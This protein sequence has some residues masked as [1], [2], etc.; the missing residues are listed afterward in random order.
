MCLTFCHSAPSL[1]ADF[2][3]QNMA[4]MQPYVHVHPT[5]WHRHRG[6]LGLDTNCRVGQSCRGLEYNK[7]S[8]LVWWLLNFLQLT[9]TST[10]KYDMHNRSV[11]IQTASIQSIHSL[12]LSFCV[13]IPFTR[14]RNLE[15]I[16]LVFSLISPHW[17]KF[18]CL[19][20]KQQ[21]KARKNGC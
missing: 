3:R 15:E 13:S 19:L 10:S 5:A 14:T 4:D 9:E 8:P 18:Y 20:C 2:K 21:I 11:P 12:P 7:M 6:S 16:K 1:F 17:D